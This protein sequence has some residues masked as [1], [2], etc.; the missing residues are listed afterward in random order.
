MESR[1][2]SKVQLWVQ[3]LALS[4]SVSILAFLPGC[5]A[6]SGVSMTGGTAA[7]EAAILQVLEADDFFLDSVTDTSEDE[8]G[9]GAAQAQIYENQVELQSLSVAPGTAELPRFWWR[10]DLER[11]GRTVDIHIENGVADVKVVHD[12]AGTFFIADEV[13]GVLILWGKPFEDIVTR[14]A[15]FTRSSWGWRLTAISPVEFALAESEQQ[16]AFIDSVRA[17]SGDELV[18]EATD[19][20][21]LFTVKEGLP[22]FTHGEEVRVEATVI[23]T[24]DNGWDPPQFVFLHRPGPSIS[25]RRTRDRMFDDGTNGDLVAGDGVYTRIYTIGPCRGR[26][27]AAVDV[28]DAATFMVF[29][30][31]YDSGAWG[32][33]YIVE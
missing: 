17:Y 31:P 32:M 29:E 9:A 12:I 3:I 25:G 20:A 14:Y 10:G 33:P 5:G 1:K 15:Q 19:P 6:G 22:V 24:A 7:D 18:W 30:A 26:H 2:A 16:T 27:F 8:E 13:D 28:I 21:T 23:N 4:T 11:L